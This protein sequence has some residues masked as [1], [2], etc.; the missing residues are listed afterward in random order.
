M[1]TYE[2]RLMV[3]DANQDNLAN[4]DARVCRYCLYW[5]SPKEFGTD[6]AKSSA[7]WRR[8]EPYRRPGVGGKIAYLGARPVGYAH[9]GPGHVFSER[10]A[11]YAAG[12]PSDDA[13]FLAC[14]TVEESARGKGVGRAL[15]E[16]VL[17]EAQRRGV[18]AVETYARRGSTNNPSGPL[19]LY[20]RHGFHIRRGDAEFPLV[21][22]ELGVV[23]VSCGIM[24][25]RAQGRAPAGI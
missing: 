15:L 20:L 21:R 1:V 8:R 13:L 22:R 2:P 10:V 6:L 18:K 19:E 14:L 23:R 4:L 11:E 9:F 24:A 25:Y 12:P 5:E 3:V 7:D 16:A 17:A